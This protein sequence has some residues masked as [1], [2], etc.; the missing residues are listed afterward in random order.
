MNSSFNNLI[1]GIF[2]IDNFRV[3]SLRKENNGFEGPRPEKRGLEIAATRTFLCNYCIGI[4]VS[5]II[6]WRWVNLIGRLVQITNP[7]KTCW[8]STWALCY[9]IWGKSNMWDKLSI[10]Y[11]AYWLNWVTRA[12]MLTPGYFASWLSDVACFNFLAL[13]ISY[14]RD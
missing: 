8:A 12:Y 11:W 14:K 1:H 5:M 13:F 3:K 6:F 2:V 4:I 7:V 9:S 10:Y